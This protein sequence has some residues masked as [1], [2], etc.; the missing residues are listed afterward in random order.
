MEVVVDTPVPTVN[1]FCKKL[2]LKRWT[3]SEYASGTGNYFRKCFILDVWLGFK[4]TSD[5]FKEAFYFLH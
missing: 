3:S 2:H 5:I 4:K 1:Y